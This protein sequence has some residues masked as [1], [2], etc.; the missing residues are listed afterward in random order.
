MILGLGLKGIPPLKKA[1]IEKLL[2]SKPKVRKGIKG[3]KNIV[4]SSSSTSIENGSPS[5]SKKAE[6]A[7]DLECHNVTTSP[8]SNKEAGNVGA[9]GIE[10]LHLKSVKLDDKRDDFDNV[11]GIAHEHAII[12]F[13]MFKWFFHELKEI[14]IN[15]RALGS[16]MEAIPASSTQGNQNNVGNWTEDKKKS[17][18]DC[19]K[20]MSEG[21]DQLKKRL[22]YHITHVDE[23]Y[24][25]IQDTLKTIMASNHKIVKQTAVVINTMVNS[26]EQKD[27]VVVI[28]GDDAHEVA[29]GGEGPYKRT[30]GNMKKKVAIQNVD[31][32]AIKIVV[33][34]MNVLEAEVAK[35]LKSLM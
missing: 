17:V 15:Q 28:I 9:V 11:L 26:L 34:T 25:K 21:V 22:E 35:T 19:I 10:D 5:S 7:K 18:M 14:R 31:Y 13:N 23:G 32:K 24:N 1:K 6:D 30:R 4:M 8:S 16:K 33:D 3:Q 20:K 29:Q 12:T 2:S 27:R